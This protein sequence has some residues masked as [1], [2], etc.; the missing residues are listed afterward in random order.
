LLDPDPGVKIAIKLF[1]KFYA[2]IFVKKALLNIFSHEKKMLSLRRKYLDPDPESQL[3]KRR[4]R[5]CI[6]SM[7]IKVSH[8]PGHPDSG[9]SGSGSTTLRVS[10]YSSGATEQGSKKKV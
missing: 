9:G 3:E 8:F 10:K 4:I 2:G 5:T 7:R 6:K 1:K